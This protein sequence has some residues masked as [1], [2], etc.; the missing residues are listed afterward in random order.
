M[1]NEIYMHSG[2]IKEIKTQTDYNALIIEHTNVRHDQKDKLMCNLKAMR[3]IRFSLPLET[4]HLVSSCDT[5]K[6]IWDRLKE[7]Y[8]GDVDLEHF[9]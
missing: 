6:R 1:T 8:S 7:L 9:L 4:F 3:I 2:T 5:A